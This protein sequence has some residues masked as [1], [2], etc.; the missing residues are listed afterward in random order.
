MN[1]KAILAIF[2]KDLRDSS[3]NY[4]VILMVITPIL[5]SLLFSNVVTKSRSE[6][7]LPEIGI[8]SNPKQPL[9]NSLISKG[10]SKKILFFKNR[11]EL[12]ASILEGKVKFGMILPEMISTRNDFTS[13]TSVVL[14]YPPHIPEFGIESLRTTFE[15]E[16]RQQLNLTP[17]PLPFNFV[18]EPVSGS[19]NR[20][21]GLTEGMF[22]MLMV[23]AMG[24]IGFLALPMSIVEE[25][26]KGT[27]NAIFLTPLKTSEFIFGK[28][29]FSFCLAFATIATILTINNK[30]GTNFGYLLA[31]II[32]GIF[33]TIFIGLTISLFAKNQGSVNAIGTTVFLFFQMVPSLQNTSEII[34]QI[35]PLVPST[36]LFNGI[37]KAIFLDLSKVDIYSDFFMA[38]AITAF[39]YIFCF[40]LF[41]LKKADK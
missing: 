21:G 14:L 32:T 31:F 11:A 39:T 22:P 3:K 40:T 2:K 26:E 13:S 18:T 20:A 35:A 9:V 34:S 23:M 12:E 10:L 24:M 37:R 38:A 29:L 33:M 27:L 1:L 8:I 28:A 41:K 15:S 36:Y 30:W 7:S 16:I 5:L 6:S 17:P 19:K 4:Q 25:R